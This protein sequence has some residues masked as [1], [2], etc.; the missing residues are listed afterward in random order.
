MFACACR[1]SELQLLATSEMNAEPPTTPA[2]PPNVAA[3]YA[4]IGDPADPLRRMPAC[5]RPQRREIS[6]FDVIDRSPPPSRAEFAVRKIPAVCA[7]RAPAI[8]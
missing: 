2:C 4:N 7:E 5:R 3:H 8:G 6:S 1:P